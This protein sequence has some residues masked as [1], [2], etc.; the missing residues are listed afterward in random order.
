MNDLSKAEFMS[1]IER[2]HEQQRV[3]DKKPLR[4]QLQEDVEEF[5]KRGGCIKALDPNASAFD[6][7]GQ[8]YGQGIMGTH[9]AAPKNRRAD[10]NE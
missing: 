2:M 6:T 3:E 7:G 10:T 4:R 9:F 5:I 1:A 8:V